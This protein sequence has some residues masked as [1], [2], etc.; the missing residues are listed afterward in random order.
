MQIEPSAVLVALVSTVVPSIVGW[1]T[2]RAIRGVDDTLGSLARK[3]DRLTEQD[4]KI[5]VDL[6]DL[7]ARVIHL[8][9][10]VHDR[11]DKGT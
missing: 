3:I 4:T 1:L 2:S 9:V 10:L 8:E 7:R 5:Q 11:I 6:A